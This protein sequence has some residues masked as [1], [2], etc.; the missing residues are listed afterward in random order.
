MRTTYRFEMI[1]ITEQDQLQEWQYEYGYHDYLLSLLS[2][3]TFEGR[4]KEQIEREINDTENMSKEMYDR[5]VFKL[6]S[7]QLDRITSGLNYSATDI[8]K[9][10]RKFK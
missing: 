2:T 3:S 4:L 1:N 6:Y 8:L 7:N 10:L 9:H 5:I